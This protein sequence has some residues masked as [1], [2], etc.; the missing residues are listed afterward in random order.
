M[1]SHHIV[2]LLIGMLLG[3]KKSDRLAWN[4]VSAPKVEQLSVKSNSITSFELSAQFTSSGHDP[5]AQFG[6]CFST[7]NQNPTI[8]DQVIYLSEGMEELVPPPYPGIQRRHCFAGPLLK[9]KSLRFI[10]NFFWL[11]G[12]EMRKINPISVMYFVSMFN[13]IKLI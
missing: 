7:N 5:K 4:L 10:Q 2:F 3:C 11:Y 6:F 12:L 9:I 8:N 1:R 13:F